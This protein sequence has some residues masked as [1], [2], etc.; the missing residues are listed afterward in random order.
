MIVLL[1]AEIT[2]CIQPCI[3]N[4]KENIMKKYFAVING[5]TGGIGSAIAKHMANHFNLI[6][7]GRDKKSLQNLSEEIKNIIPDTIV[8]YYMVDMLEPKTL[9]I[10]A[11]AIEQ[12]NIAIRALVNSVGVVPVG[13]LLDVDDKQWG[14]TFQI[15]FMSA[16]HLIKNFTPLM[17]KDGGSIVIV[18]GVLAIQPEANFI[19]SSSV[20]G[21]LRNF[22][23]AISKDLSRYRIRVNTIL[24]GGTLTSLWHEITYE[25]GKKLNLT[26]DELSQNI[27]SN[28]PLRRLAEPSDIAH[29][30]NF[31]CSEAA[32]YINGAFLT[33][34]GGGSL[35]M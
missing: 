29:A 15:G 9:A 18:N 25:L 26:A 16:V 24:P 7:L 20:T 6:L 28:N 22:A 13:S 19:I 8:Q 30:A 3:K 1:L 5:S 12:Q 2:V 10:A 14:D 4:Y 31:L 23:K 21:A 11:L 35:A 32:A 33:I 34:D 27:A 17:Q